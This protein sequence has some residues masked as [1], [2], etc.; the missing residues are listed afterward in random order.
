MAT[1]SRRVSFDQTVAVVVYDRAD[2]EL[3]CRASQQLN[4]QPKDRRQFVSRTLFARLHKSTCTPPPTF[5]EVPR[6]YCSGTSLTPSSDVGMERRPLP[7]I[8]SPPV[9]RDNISSQTASG[10]IEFAFHEDRSGQLLLS[11][12]VP[13]GRGVAA[14]DA[15]VKANVAGISSNSY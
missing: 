3:V 4:T 10:N 13:L 12:T 7:S 1:P 9:A 2:G 5:D 6:H 15:V 8:Q 11:F 14:G